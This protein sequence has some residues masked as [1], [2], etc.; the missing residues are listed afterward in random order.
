MS[1][2]S[3][4]AHDYALNAD[5][6][7]KFNEA[8]LIL[9]RRCLLGR[10]GNGETEETVR[11]T[12]HDLKGLVGSLVAA[13]HDEG[14]AWTVDQAQVPADLLERLRK[15]VKGALEETITELRGVVDDLDKGVALREPAFKALDVVC[16][17]ADET[18]SAAFRRLRRI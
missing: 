5:F 2:L 9:K 8:V 11:Q 15:R 13:L 17:A 10:V 1:E 18:A 7:R 14:K 16:E 12:R 3:I 4:I 6:A